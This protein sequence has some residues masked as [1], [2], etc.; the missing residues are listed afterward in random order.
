MGEAWAALTDAASAEFEP[1][2]INGDAG[3][4]PSRL[5]TEPTATACIAV[6]L[7]AAGALQTLRT[8]SLPRLD[9]DRRHVAA[10]V[11][12]ERYYRTGT[13]ST[14]M[15]FAPFAL[16]ARPRRMGAHPH[17]LSVASRCVVAH[18]WS[19]GRRHR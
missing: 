12:S 4:L 10:A 9:L 19:S 1:P 17:E 11:R 13:R 15:G 16:L 3:A 14:G 2:R 6:A 7:A 5:S 8:G 18:T